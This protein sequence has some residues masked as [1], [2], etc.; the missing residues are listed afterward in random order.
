MLPRFSEDLFDRQPN[1]GFYS[2]LVK[3]DM[4]HTA[5]L[6]DNKSDFLALLIEPEQHWM[7]DYDGHPT[8]ESSKVYKALCED[9]VPPILVFLFLG[10]CIG[11]CRHGRPLY[12][13]PFTLL[14]T[15]LP[16]ERGD[17]PLFYP[18]NNFLR[19]RFPVVALD[20]ANS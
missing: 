5:M 1:Q 12:S 9:S 18:L 20:Q 3:E 8:E 4:T 19:G 16:V 15:F 10:D 13:G 7:F 2:R 11:T 14:N 6:M 17:D